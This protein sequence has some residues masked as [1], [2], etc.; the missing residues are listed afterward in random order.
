[1]HIAPRHIA[2]RQR[3]CPAPLDAYATQQQAPCNATPGA[4]AAAAGHSKGVSTGWT[5]AA[6]SMMQQDV[7]LGPWARHQD[8]F[9]Q[10]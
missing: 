1:M 4:R 10:Q 9:Y 7:R 5:A 2:P 8:A 3:R 6:Q